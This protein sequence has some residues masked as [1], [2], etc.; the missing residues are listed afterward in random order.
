MAARERVVYLNGRI[1]PES[2]ASISIRD[3]GFLAGD[4]VFDT[5]RTFNGQVFKLREHIGRLFRSLK[6][7]QIDPGLTPEQFEEMTL[8]VARQN[9]PLLGPHEDYWVSQRVTRGVDPAFAPQGPRPTVLIECRPL[10]LKERA[11]YYAQGA[12]VYTPTL[13]RTSPQSLSPNAKTHNYLNM[14]L[15]SLEVH[16]IDPLGWAIL[17]DENGNLAEGS[18]SNIFVY[19][20]GVLLTPHARY[21]L[22]GITRQTVMELAQGLGIPTQ[23]ADLSLFETYTADEV[24]LTSTSLCVCPVTSVNQI[25][26]RD[27][28]VPG[29]VTERLLQAFSDLAGLDIRAQ[30]LAHLEEENRA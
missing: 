26:I 14:V 10:P 2:Q 12:P 19:R 30:Y 18:G 13:R 29:P 1:I 17:L 23:E 24:F 5:E 9:A 21:V 22:P 15:G 6:Y 11:V 20:E 25:P 7:V 3:R 8:E 28:R 16:T 4:A 27:G